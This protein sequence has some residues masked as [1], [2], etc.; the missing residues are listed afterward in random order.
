MREAIAAQFSPP[1]SLPA[2]SAFLHDRTT[3]RTPRSTVLVSRSTRPSSRSR[4]AR[5]VVQRIA[6]RAGRWATGRQARHMQFEPG[7]QS[8]I[9]GRVSACRTTSPCSALVPRMF[10][11]MRHS[12]GQQPAGPCQPWE[13][14]PT[15]PSRNSPSW[16]GHDLDRAPARRFHRQGSA[17]SS[18]RSPEAARQQERPQQPC[19]RPRIPLWSDRPECLG[20]RASAPG[21]ATVGD[22]QRGRPARARPL[23]LSADHPGSVA[24]ARELGRRRPHISGWPASPGAIVAS[25]SSRPSC[26]C[27][28]DGVVAFSQG[29]PR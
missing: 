3:R 24:A 15:R 2:N 1:S 7:T 29:C 17:P 25:R 28:S 23:P 14:H 19:S 16:S 27:F 8:R 11:P 6:D 12:C 9:S 10:A 21:D 5:P 26:S 4:P 20:A 18:V 13:D 22:Q